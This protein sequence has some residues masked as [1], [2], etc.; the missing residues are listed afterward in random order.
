MNPDTRAVTDLPQG[1]VRPTGG[2]VHPVSG[3]AY[4]LLR[5]VRNRMVSMNLGTQAVC[6]RQPVGMGHQ[7]GPD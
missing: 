2:V 6:C 1:V 3:G 7:G 4:L 5:L